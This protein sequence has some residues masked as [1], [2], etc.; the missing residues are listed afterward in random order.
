MLEL[1]NIASTSRDKAEVDAS[2]EEVLKIISDD[3]I[4]APLY[5][6]DNQI[7]YNKDLKGVHNSPIGMHNLYALHY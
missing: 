7:A 3:A 4:W 1:V 2:Y 6:L 5:T